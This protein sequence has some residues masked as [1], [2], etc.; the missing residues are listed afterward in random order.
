MD[1]KRGFTCRYDFTFLIK[2]LKSETRRQSSEK[3]LLR[4]SRRYV[5]FASSITDVI[6]R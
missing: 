5:A 6:L 2:T 3:L 4:I 1:A